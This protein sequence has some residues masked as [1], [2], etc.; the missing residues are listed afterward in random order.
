MEHERFPVE[1]R[2]KERGKQGQQTPNRGKVLKTI[3]TALDQNSAQQ[4]KGERR[5]IGWRGGRLTLTTLC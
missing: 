2:K 3:G 4:K 1:E 5:N